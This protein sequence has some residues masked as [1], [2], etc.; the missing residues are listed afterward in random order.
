MDG[1]ILIVDSLLDAS[2]VFNV[3]VVTP[4]RSQSQPSSLNDDIMNTTQEAMC[5]NVVTVNIGTEK[6]PE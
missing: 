5:R 2:H 4:H 6:F 1:I 3:N